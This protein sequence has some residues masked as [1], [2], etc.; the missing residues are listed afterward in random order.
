MN[1]SD[2]RKPLVSIRGFTILA[3]FFTVGTSILVA[4]TGLAFHAKQDAWMSCLIGIGINLALV[5]MY[6]VLGERYP[7]QTIVQYSRTLLGRWFGG[8]AGLLFIAFYYLLAALLVADLGYFLSTQVMSDTP[9]EAMAIVFIAA[10]GFTVREGMRV[11]SLTA[12]VLFPWVAVL[13]IVLF[14]PVVN[15]FDVQ[16]LQPMLE[17]GF[18][19]V[20]QGAASFS[21]LQEMNVF[22]MMYPFVA[23]GKGKGRRNGFLAGTAIGG[24]VLAVTTTGSLIVLGAE[25]T[26]NH[27]Y[28]SYA[29]AKNVQLGH[30]VE[31]VEGVL[32]F[33]WICSVFIKTTITLHASVIG[34]NQMLGIRDPKLL[35]WPMAIGLFPIGLMSY[36]NAVFTTTFIN[37]YWTPFALPFEV[38]LP[39]VLLGVSLVR[40]GRRYDRLSGGSS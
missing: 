11:Y 9:L 15:E 8:A 36:T 17:F 4:P 21:M 27:L 6:S 19:P 16:M 12:E 38:L 18:A 23:K 39:L 37:R 13:L 40:H 20:V 10:V 26:A 14:L 2:N 30:M 34:V 32:M 7:D 29:L 31:R 1:G 28:P 33:I 24:A 35:V 22:L 5:W 25:L 3:M